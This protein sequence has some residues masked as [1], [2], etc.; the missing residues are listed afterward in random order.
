MSQTN[1]VSLSLVSVPQVALKIHCNTCN[2]VNRHRP[3]RDPYENELEG[4]LV[5]WQ[6]VQCGGCDGVSF[7]REVTVEG[8]EDTQ[9]EGFA[10]PLRQYKNPEHFS[11]APENL[12]RLYRETIEAYNNESLLLCAGGLRT[13]V[14][15]I[16]VQQNVT[17]GPV[18][19]R[20]T[21]A[22]HRKTNLE[23]KIGGL[24]EKHILTSTEATTL[25]QHRYLG[26]EA[27]H[28][29]RVPDKNALLAA[30]G[31]IEH[32]MKTLYDLSAQA[33]AISAS[34]SSTQPAPSLGI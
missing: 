15:G 10:Y 2:R 23:G 3:V 16:C 13:I 34:R 29:L 33:Q 26:N 5:S 11:N 1:A 30:I 14:E 32:I 21:G 17:D 8:E 25:H 6:I 7:Y 24:A 27:L 12:S 9:T 28:E 19:N 22:I 31:I 4:E 20:D 18:E